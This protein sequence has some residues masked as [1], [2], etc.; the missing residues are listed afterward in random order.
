MGDLLATCS[1]HL[2]RNYRVGARLAK[3]EALEKVLADLGATAEGVRTSQV[4]WEFA[5]KRGIE[6]PITY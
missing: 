4:V 3:G 1:S 5:E 6:M 2:S